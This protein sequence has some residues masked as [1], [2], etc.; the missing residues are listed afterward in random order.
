MS[1]FLINADKW[2]FAKLFSSFFDKSINMSNVNPA[3][4]HYPKIRINR[5]QTRTRRRMLWYKTGRKV[6]R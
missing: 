6:K 1:P 3:F 4:F 2:G 5:S